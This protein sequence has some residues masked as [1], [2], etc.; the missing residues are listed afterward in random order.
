M[1]RRSPL[2]FDVSVSAAKQKSARKR[3]M[4]GRVETSKRLCEWEGC[5]KHGAY[6]APRSR[7]NVNDF[8]WFCLDHVREYNSRWN[9]YA[10][11][12]EDEIAASMQS[13]QLWGRPTWTLG[14]GPRA[15]WI[16]SPHLDG[17]AWKRFGFDD[18]LQV[19]GENA[20]LNPGAREDAKAARARLLP[21]AVRRA[22]DVMELDSLATREQIR[23]RYKELVKRYHP[24]QNGGDRSEEARLREVLWAWDQLKNHE[25]FK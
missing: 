3:G 8:R 4:T 7:D 16:A 5:E 10:D 15:S 12:T 18:P 19:L 17:E 24:D 20:T 6:R 1:S 2:E 9:Y 21:Q 23:L 11:M 25:A 13:D 22:L 14:K